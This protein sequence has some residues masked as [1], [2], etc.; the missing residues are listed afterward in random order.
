MLTLTRRR[1]KATTTDHS[2]VRSYIRTYERPTTRSIDQPNEQLTDKPCLTNEMNEC[3]QIK[4][5]RFVCLIFKWRQ[6]TTNSQAKIIKLGFC[7][8]IFHPKML[9]PNNDFDFGVFVS[10]FFSHAEPLSSSLLEL[11][12]FPSCE[13]TTKQRIRITKNCKTGMAT[14]A[15]I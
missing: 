13:L 14:I 12:I 1:T 9:R 4:C 11:F 5:E 15:A 8:F 2:Y 7:I 10:H 3:M 6:M